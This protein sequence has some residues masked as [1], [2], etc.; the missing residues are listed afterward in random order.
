MSPWEV[1]GYMEK[2]RACSQEHSLNAEWRW[3]LKWIKAK[4]N[5]ANHLQQVSCFFSDLEYKTFKEYMY[6]QSYFYIKSGDKPPLGVQI[7]C[8]PL[9]FLPL[10]GGR[11][12][13]I[14]H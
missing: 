7:S 10:G 5:S 12:P 13:D 14:Y 3:M 4:Y 1:T 9:I 11:I 8:F 2:L 6:Y